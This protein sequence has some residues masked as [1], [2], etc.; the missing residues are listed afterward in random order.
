MDLMLREGY[1]AFDCSLPNSN[2]TTWY[3]VYGIEQLLLGL[4][5]IPPFALARLPTMLTHNLQLFIIATPKKAGDWESFVML[6]TIIY[7][8]VP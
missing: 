7:A 4:V 2:S 1:G 5:L 6:L 8:T 3:V